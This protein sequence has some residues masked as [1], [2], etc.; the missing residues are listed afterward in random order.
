M[1]PHL[2]DRKSCK[3][4]LS[5]QEYYALELHKNFSISTICRPYISE[6]DDRI[7]VSGADRAQ[8]LTR[9]QDALKRGADAFLHLLFISDRARRSWAF[10]Y[11]GLTLVLLLSLMKETRDS[12]D[13]RL[14]QSQIIN[15]LEQENEFGS[16]STPANTNRLWDTHR[17]ALEALKALKKLSERET[18]ATVITPTIA[19]E[20][21]FPEGFPSR[22]KYCKHSRLNFQA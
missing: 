22:A 17:K 1:S 8:I 11:N 4:I 14:L 6:N 10:I 19:T 21:L 20:I 13:T 5:I 16:D 3:T 18:N 7:R 15:S 12:K 2:R 9:L